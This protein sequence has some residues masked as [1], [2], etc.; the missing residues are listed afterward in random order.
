MDNKSI[1]EKL[2]E[3][4]KAVDEICKK[5]NLSYMLTQGTLLGAIRE[6]GFIEW[7][8]EDADL[9]MHRKDFNY[10]I[11]YCRENLDSLAFFLGKD[12]ESGL[13]H[14]LIL[15]QNPEIFVE[16]F[17]IDSLPQNK[18]KRNYKILSL[19]LINGMIREHNSYSGKSIVH[20]IKTFG[21]GCLGRLFGH[22]TKLK[23][24]NT[25]SQKWN[26]EDSNSV[27][28]SNEDSVKMIHEFDRNL[29]NEAIRVPFEDTELLVPKGWDALLKFYYGDD[30]MTPRR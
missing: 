19:R 29:F 27:F 16:I 25:V 5:E 11:R 6:K 24:Y 1:H 3:I 8:I 9:M 17:L 10:F 14:R 26:D 21:I 30:Y 20:K 2:L 12:P 28:L 18:L 22:D 7:D 4:L 13:T 23:L 15:K